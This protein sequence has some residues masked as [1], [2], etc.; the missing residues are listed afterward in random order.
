MQSVQ[1]R[2]SFLA[3]LTTAGFA[4]LAGPRGACSEEAPLETTVVRFPKSPGM[5]FAPQFIAEDLLRAEGFSDFQQVSSVAGLRST[6]MLARGEVDFSIDYAIAFVIPIDAGAPI[7]VLTGVHVGCYEL[8]AHEGINSVLDL[9]GRRV[10]AGLNLGSDP[11][12][13]VSAMASHVG[14]DPLKD[15]NW[16]TSDVKGIDLFMQRKVDAFLSFPPEVQELRARHIGH[17]IVSSILDR[18]WS[19]YFCCMLAANANYAAK[20]PAATKRVVRAILKA[21][22]FCVSD[23]ERVARLLIDR[24]YTRQFDPALQALMEIPYGKW[25]EY[26]PEDTIRFFALRLHEAGMIKSSPQKIIADGTDW[27]LLKELKR[28]LKA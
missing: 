15:I 17:V 22:D 27:R 3:G 11:Y 10:A 25:R 5:C 23:P 4:A 26:D 12:I 24:G 6:A 21:S 7:K 28:E 8:I 19:Q 18:P 13:F 1:N 16:I 20:Y 9:K 2:R 14:L